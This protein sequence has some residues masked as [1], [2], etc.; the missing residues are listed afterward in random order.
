MNAQADEPAFTVVTGNADDETSIQYQNGTAQ[1]DIYS[2][3][4]IGFAAVELES[5]V[6]PEEMILRLHLQGL[7]Q[8]QLTSSQESIRASVSSDGSFNVD[9]QTIL[10]AGTESPLQSG[11]PLWMEIEVVSGQAEKKIPLEDGYFEVTV[12]KEFL[13]NAGTSFEIEWIDFFR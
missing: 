10:S 3:S 9:D 2:P 12:P 8:L 11:N 4:G 7:E 1:I 13:K 5:G 6:M